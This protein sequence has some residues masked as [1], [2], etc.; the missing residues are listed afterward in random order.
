M[1]FM[2]NSEKEFSIWKSYDDT[3]EPLG[4][5]PETI[6]YVYRMESGCN[7]IKDSLNS[8]TNM[9][10]TQSFQNPFLSDINKEIQEFE[11]IY[12]EHISKVLPLPVEEP[13]L[14]SN[15]FI[16]SKN[17]DGQSLDE[18]KD[19]LEMLF[20]TAQSNL[21]TTTKEESIESVDNSASDLQGISNQIE[22]LKEFVSDFSEEKISFQ[23]KKT[24][25][26]PINKSKNVKSRRWNNPNL[27]AYETI[28]KYLL[29]DHS[30][31]RDGAIGRPR[32]EKEISVDSLKQQ[33]EPVLSKIKI[34]INGVKQRTNEIARADQIT[35]SFKRLVCDIPNILLH[36]NGWKTHYKSRD[37]EI[38]LISWIESFKTCFLT[39]SPLANSDELVE[40]FL[41]YIILKFPKKVVEKVIDNV[42]SSQVISADTIKLLYALQEMSRCTSKEDISDYYKKSLA[43]RKIC[44]LVE[45]LLILDADVD[46]DNLYEILYKIRN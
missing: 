26:P 25:L 31:R 19:K 33:L 5:S 22:E 16:S 13:N 32:S 38:R 34:S 14:K 11:S 7:Y 20:D 43:F 23:S 4:N 35:T 45:G 30:F 17:S 36:N 21:I 18:F 8:L 15:P 6:K 24:D 37:E 42:W 39:L 2:N 12:E 1:D 9:K 46:I 3:C 10:I 28:K 40:L 29:N 44:E 27:N 41:S